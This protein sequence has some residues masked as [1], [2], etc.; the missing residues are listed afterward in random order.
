MAAAS[1]RRGEVSG[2]SEEGAEPEVTV[3]FET[4]FIKVP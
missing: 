3:D 4:F 2:G 1:V